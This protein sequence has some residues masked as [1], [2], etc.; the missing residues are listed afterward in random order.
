MKPDPDTQLLK[1]PDKTPTPEVLEAELGELYP[2]YSELLGMLESDEF[3]LGYEWRY[4]KDA[5]GWLCK[6]TRKKKTVVWMSAWRDC[7]SLGFYFTEKTGAGIPELEIDPGLK[8][9]YA[10]ADPVGKMKPLTVELKESNQLRDLGTLL[11]YKI[12]KL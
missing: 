10:T 12:S 6:I 11:R 2:L 5:K 4:Y 3:C 9:N 8:Q 7:L 1:N